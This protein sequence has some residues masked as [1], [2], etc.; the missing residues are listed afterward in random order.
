MAKSNK[1]KKSGQS[2]RAQQQQDAAR[3]RGAGVAAGRGST[4]PVQATAQA[5][6]A[7]PA[8]SGGR[9]EPRHYL[10]VSAIR[11]QEWLARTPD[12]K[13]RRGASVLL[14]EATARGAW[15]ELPSGMCWNDKA[16]DVDG[17]VSLVLAETTAGE[18]PEDQIR[19]A[20]CAV[21]R[22]L[23]QTMPYC[24][25]QAVAGMG[26][27]YAGAYQQMADARRN[28]HLLV[29]SPPAPPELIVA[30]PCDQ[31]RSAAATHPNV[32]GQET[33]ALCDDCHARFSAAGGTAAT[34]AG[35]RARNSGCAKHW[36]R[37]G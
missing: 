4:P 36:R 20:A 8:T 33:K 11:I 29:N 24:P 26:V 21:A 31:C 7:A 18:N 17:V 10:D 13:F 34:A 3:R 15:T 6:P 22:R 37:P 14:T 30:K 5:A 2:S 1:N 25:V 35:N 28:G 32:A 9:T 19:A 12:L 23:R 27:S 16:G